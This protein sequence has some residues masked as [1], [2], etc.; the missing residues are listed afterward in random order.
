[1]STPVVR[2]PDDSGTGCCP[3]PDQVDCAC[4][5]YPC[6]LSCQNKGGVATLCGYEEFTDPSTP[7]KK[8]RRKDTNGTALVCVGYSTSACTPP[9]CSNSVSFSAFYSGGTIC[10]IPFDVSGSGAMSLIGEVSPG[11]WRYSISCSVTVGG[12][13]EGAQIRGSPQG[14]GPGFTSSGGTVDIASGAWDVTL[15]TT[16]GGLCA[17]DGPK[18]ITSGVDFDATEDEWALVEQYAQSD[19]AFTQSGTADRTTGP[20]CPPAETTGSIPCTP[21]NC[22]GGSSFFTETTDSVSREFAGNGCVYN[23]TNYTNATGTVEEVLSVEDTAEDAIN[24][25]NA[26]KSWAASG[27]VGSEAFITEQSAV[28][29]F[30]YR[31]AQVRALI[32]NLTIGL[33]YRTTIRFYR[34]ACC[35]GNGAWFSLGTA[36]FDY[37]A[38]AT[39]ELTTWVDIPNEVGFETA[40]LAC[41]TELVP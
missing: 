33:H 13:P 2:V 31:S 28:F 3:C 21:L 23:G 27:C 40:P 32:Q 8:Y 22:Y 17:L 37:T 15:Y 41:G 39:E 4:G 6:L 18:C 11:V 35:G 38:S 34:R 36:V 26:S 5:P 19:C 29:S 7:P 30:G 14:G 12:N 25:A 20:T 9:A 16:Y 10:G 24:R 1:M